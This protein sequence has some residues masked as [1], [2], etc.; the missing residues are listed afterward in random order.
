MLYQ[1][2]VCY[3]ELLKCVLHSAINMHFLINM[4]QGGINLVKSDS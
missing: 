4:H 3:E 1:S 2:F